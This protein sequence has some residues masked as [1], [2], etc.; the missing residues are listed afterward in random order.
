MAEVKPKVL[1]VDDELDLIKMVS[2]RLALE[3]FEVLLAKDGEEAIAKAREGHPD[4]IVLD[5]MMP[6]LSGFEV[7]QMLKKDAQFQRTPVIFFS[8]KYGGMEESELREWGASAFLSKSQGSPAL[9]AQIKALLEK[10][11]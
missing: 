7:C 4:V 9:I 11:D 3:G 6:R 2:K 1:V 8:G 5:L 10:A